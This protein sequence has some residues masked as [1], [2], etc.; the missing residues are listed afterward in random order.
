[1]SP[2]DCLEMPVALQ[3]ELFG[4]VQIVFSRH[5]VSS[6]PAAPVPTDAGAAK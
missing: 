1:M 6:E 3:E 5:V 2:A 4:C